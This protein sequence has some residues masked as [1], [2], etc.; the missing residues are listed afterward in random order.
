MGPLRPFQGGFVLGLSQLRPSFV[1]L[2]NEDALD[3]VEP[4]VDTKAHIY[5]ASLVAWTRY[6]IALGFNVC[7]GGGDSNSICWEG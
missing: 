4:D 2:F 6:L 7:P 1:V 5:P 3:S